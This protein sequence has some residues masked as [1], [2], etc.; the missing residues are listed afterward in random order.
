MP[1]E[2]HFLSSTHLRVTKES[3]ISLSQKLK[4]KEGQTPISQQEISLKVSKMEIILLGN[5]IFK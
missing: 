5:G 4:L 1:K 2:K 3:G